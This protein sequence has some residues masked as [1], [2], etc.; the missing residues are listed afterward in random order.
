MTIWSNDPDMEGM[1]EAAMAAGW[2]E[3][4]GYEWRK[5]YD[6]AAGRRTGVVR[7]IRFIDT[8]RGAWHARVRGSD[9]FALW[10]GTFVDWRDALS[11]ADAAAGDGE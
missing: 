2:I 7:L 6:C 8:D 3:G 11:A 4:V 10:G 5:R 9:G 1:R